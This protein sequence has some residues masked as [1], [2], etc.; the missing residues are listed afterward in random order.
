MNVLV[1]TSGWYALVVSKDLFHEQARNF[2]QKSPIVTTSSLIFEEVLALVHA[3]QGKL[4]ALKA[5]AIIKAYCEGR[6]LYISSVDNEE[7]LDIYQKTG[8]SIDYVDASVVWLSR[9][10]DLPVFTFDAHF[11]KMN[12][13][14]VH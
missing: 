1:D 7:I 6:F 3:R 2:F 9:R 13:Q 14:V 11:K 10:L 12:V 8:K 4:I 5:S